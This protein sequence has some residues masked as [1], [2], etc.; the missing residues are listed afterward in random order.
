[1]RVTNFTEVQNL[2]AKICAKSCAKIVL[3]MVPLELVY[4]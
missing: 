2:M 3:S 4:T 1:M